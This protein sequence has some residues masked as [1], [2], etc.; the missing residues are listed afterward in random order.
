[1]DVMQGRPYAY[2]AYPLGTIL[3]P[4]RWPPDHWS[5]VKNAQRSNYWQNL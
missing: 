4:W 3:P 2:E 1:M 5:T